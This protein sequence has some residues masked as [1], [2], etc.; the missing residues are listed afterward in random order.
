MSSTPSP[1]L[2]TSLKALTHAT[3]I[4][5][6]MDHVLFEFLARAVGGVL[7]ILSVGI[8]IPRRQSSATSIGTSLRRIPECSISPPNLLPNSTSTQVCPARCRSN[9]QRTAAP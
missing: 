9:L 1:F 4:S 6:G 3:L 5:L 8:R 7:A 2:A